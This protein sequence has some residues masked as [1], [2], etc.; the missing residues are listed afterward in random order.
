MRLDPW[1]DE[2]EQRFWR[3][4]VAAVRS[5]ERTMD[6]RLQQ[7]AGISSADFAILVSLCEAPGGSCRMRELCALLAWDRSRVSHQISRMGKRGLVEKSRCDCDQRG[8]DVR[9]TALGREI[10]E[11]TAPDH[12]ATVRHLIFDQL[13]EADLAAGAEVLERIAASAAGMRGEELALGNGAMPAGAVVE[14]HARAVAAA[15]DADAAA[16]AAHAAGD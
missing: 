7:T 14:A 6:H 16:E 13:G 2:E 9:L 5:A 11:R 3:T 12:V 10:I 1:L 8:I 15:A 4:L